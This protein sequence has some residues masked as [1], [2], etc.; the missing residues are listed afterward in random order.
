MLLQRTDVNFTQSGLPNILPY[1]A[2]FG[3]ALKLWLSADQQVTLS[4]SNVLSWKDRSSSQISVLNTGSPNPIIYTPTAQNGLPGLATAQTV[5]TQNAFLN[6]AASNAG[7][8]ALEWNVPWSLCLC[9]KF[10]AFTGTE[11]NHGLISYCASGNFY[12]G[13]WSFF[14]RITNA[15]TWQLLIYAGN[16]VAPYI[17]CS[18]QAPPALG[19]VCSVMFVYN[20]NAATPTVTVYLNGLPMTSAT[21][22][23]LT[24]SILNASRLLRVF[25]GSGGAG[26]VPAPD[27]LFEA[28]AVTG[29]LTQ[30]QVTKMDAYL[31]NKWAFH[32]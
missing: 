19:T 13:G 10:A 15:T 16:G 31:N 18:F 21:T 27:M 12:N 23:S 22:G 28:L 6:S 2:Q 7:L 8:D 30:A 1:P 29:A 4:G 25:S 3:S 5:V 14:T 17:T 11:A 24:Q 32:L 9:F 20:G 26:G